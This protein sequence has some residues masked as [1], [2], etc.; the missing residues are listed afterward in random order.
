MSTVLVP[1]DL[2]AKNIDALNRTAINAAANVDNGSIFKLGALSTEQGKS[3]V[4][5]IT[6]PA[7]DLT[8]LWMAYSPEVVLTV[9]GDFQAKGID[10]DPRHFTNV[11]GI[12]F[13]AYKIQVGDLIT[14]TAEGLSAAYNDEGYLVAQAASM[15]FKPNATAIAGVSYKVLKK[16]N[17]T[18]ANGGIGADS[19]PAYLCECVAIA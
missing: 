6:T 8:G 2:V 16:T 17:I 10:Q 18:I 7:D 4:F 3:E 12:P 5:T 1:T 9:S 13:D 19:V 15:K 14:I 11:A